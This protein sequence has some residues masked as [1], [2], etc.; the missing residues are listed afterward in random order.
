MYMYYWKPEMIRFMK[1]ASE[2]GVY[3]KDLA[4][5]IKRLAPQAESICDTGCGL[6]YLSIEL[7]HLF[8][9]VTA[10]DIDENP[11]KVLKDNID[12]NKIKNIRAVCADIDA[13]CPHEKFDAMVFCFFGK[14]EHIIKIAKEKCRGM[15]FVISRNWKNHRFSVS[16]QPVKRFT[17]D[18]MRAFLTENGIPFNEDVFSA[19]MGQPLKN[20]ENAVLFFKTYSKDENPQQIIFDDIKDRLEVLGGSEYKYYCPMHREMCVL[21]FDSGDIPNDCILNHL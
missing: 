15:V 4:K 8:K 6:G 7:S 18:T 19:E 12:N 3:H 20:E 21:S 16:E 5:L 10:V 9:S 13:Y 11:L 2:Y 14:R 17:V 1:D